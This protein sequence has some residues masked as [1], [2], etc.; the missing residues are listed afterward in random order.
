MS[1]FPKLTVGAVASR[2]GMAV[3]ALH[4]Y[5]EKGLIFSLRNSGNQRRF[6]PDTI[7]RV[8]IIKA[9]QKMGVSLDEIKQALDQLPE[10]RTPTKADWQKMSSAWQEKLCARIAQLQKFC[11][12]LDGCIG[13][14]CL[15]MTNC[16]IYN[17]DDKLKAAGPG[18]VLLQ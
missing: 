7:R 16:P 8:S 11:D 18:P 2:T 1:K 5:E 10:N 14:G 6:Y 4:F 17:P 9:A 13:C 12:N 15:S 3:S